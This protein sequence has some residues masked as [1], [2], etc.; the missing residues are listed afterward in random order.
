MGGFEAYYDLYD[1][2]NGFG[3]YGNENYKSHG[4]YDNLILYTSQLGQSNLGLHL[5]S[6][7]Q[8]V[9]ELPSGFI[10]SMNS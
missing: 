9:D 1:Y 7:N 6:I 5:A 8:Y 10:A 3:I 2:F 4:I